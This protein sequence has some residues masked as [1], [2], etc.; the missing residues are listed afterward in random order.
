MKTLNPILSLALLVAGSQ[1]FSGPAYAKG[2]GDSDTK[3]LT[4]SVKET[5][6]SGVLKNLP[7]TSA[8]VTL[9]EE[10][11]LRWDDLSWDSENDGYL[12]TVQ[13]AELYALGVDKAT[14]SEVA[15]W[16]TVNDFQGIYFTTTGDTDADGKTGTIEVTDLDGEEAASQAQRLLESI[17]QLLRMLVQAS[18]NAEE[19]YDEFGLTGMYD[20]VITADNGTEAVAV[21]DLRHGGDLVTGVIYIVEDSVTLETGSG[22]CPDYDL[23]P[24]FF[25]T[26]ATI[27]PSLNSSAVRLAAS[28]QTDRNIALDNPDDWLPGVEILVTSSFHARLLSDEESLVVDLDLSTP[29]LPF[30]NQVHV[31]GTFSRRP[32]TLWLDR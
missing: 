30:C 10:L 3:E 21:L 32:G 28:G 6:D 22:L 20:G 26:T 18:E 29:D 14:V 24:S 12:L 19:R 5:D 8:Q 7:F 1:S 27:D 17:L 15:Q 4:Q 11:G 23:P 31:S 2:N 25:Q 9:V 16:A 13:V